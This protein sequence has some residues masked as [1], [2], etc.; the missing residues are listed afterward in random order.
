MQTRLAKWGN[1]LA[2]RIPAAF[3]EEVALR[4]GDTVELTAE[5]GALVIRNRAPALR[6]ADILPLITDDNLH[7]PVDFG[8]PVGKELL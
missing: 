8:P 6:M 4:D 5:N 7:A 3:A 2:V 1:S